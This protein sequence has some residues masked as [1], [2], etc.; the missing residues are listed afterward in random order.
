MCASLASLA[1]KTSILQLLALIWVCSLPLVDIPYR[2]YLILCKSH[3]DVGRNNIDAGQ[4]PVS[5]DFGAWLPSFTLQMK[6]LRTVKYQQRRWSLKLWTTDVGRTDKQ[7]CRYN[8]L[9]VLWLSP[10]HSSTKSD[11]L[12]TSITRV[13]RKSQFSWKIPIRCR[14]WSWVILCHNCRFLDIGGIFLMK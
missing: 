9:E 7:F 10:I 14:I 12:N 8:T 2:I 5:E 4:K 11:F 3:N 6:P 13:M 1:Q